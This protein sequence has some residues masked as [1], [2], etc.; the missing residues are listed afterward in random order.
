MVM[1]HCTLYEERVEIVKVY[2]C[3]NPFLYTAVDLTC[4]AMYQLTVLKPLCHASHWVAVIRGKKIFDALYSMTYVC[5][6][7]EEY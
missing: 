4:M 3:I 1:T 5:G 6:Q 2:H 7:K